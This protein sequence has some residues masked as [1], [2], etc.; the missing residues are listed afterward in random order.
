MISRKSAIKHEKDMKQKTIQKTLYIK[1]GGFTEMGKNFINAWHKAE[2]GQRIIEKD[3]ITFDDLTSLL[4]ILSNTRLDL[5]HVLSKTGC[6]SIRQLSR[7]LERDYH[8]V[9]KDVILLNKYKFIT[10][11]DNKFYVPWS[12]I[13]IPNVDVVLNELNLGKHKKAS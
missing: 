13:S 11:K 7:Q 2:K 12:K 9:H 5:I 3:L 10:K 8:G 1:F 4:K 6:A